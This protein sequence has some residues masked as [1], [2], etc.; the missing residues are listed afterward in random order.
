ML[1]PNLNTTETRGILDTFVPTKC[2]SI[3]GVILLWVPR[4][5]N[6]YRWKQR[7]A[8]TCNHLFILWEILNEAVS[9]KTIW[10][11]KQVA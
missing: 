8:I 6:A 10:R 9:M 11:R 5:D 1:W 2:S 7:H 4:H 3:W